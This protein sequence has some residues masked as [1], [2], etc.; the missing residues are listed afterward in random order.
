MNLSTFYTDR[1]GRFETIKEE[2]S[3]RIFWLGW[4]R[5]LL[6]LLFAAC[7]YFFFKSGFQ[8]GWLISGLA[9][10]VGFLALVKFNEE[11]LD[12]F[13]KANKK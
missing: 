12:R 9:F 11:L 10:F 2:L 5:R 3:T 13:E 8:Y 6:F 7:T 4:T 1:K